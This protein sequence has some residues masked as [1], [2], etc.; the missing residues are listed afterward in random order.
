MAS[1]FPMCAVL[2]AA[3]CCCR[4]QVPDISQISLIFP[5]WAWQQIC[6]VTKGLFL[7]AAGVSKLSSSSGEPDSDAKPN[8]RF[9]APRR[10]PSCKFIHFKTSRLSSQSENVGVTVSSQ[11]LAMS[12]AR[13]CSAHRWHSNSNSTESP[14]CT[15][16]AM[17]PI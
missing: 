13:S 3:N 4:V 17:P 8:D 6:A 14:L 10:H 15:G 1:M 7:K 2:G 16:G 12:S 11:A 5:A 9:K